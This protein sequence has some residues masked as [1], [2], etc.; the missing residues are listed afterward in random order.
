MKK[1]NFF[2]KKAITFF[3]DLQASTEVYPERYLGEMVAGMILYNPI[4][5]II[6]F[7]GIYFLNRRKRMSGRKA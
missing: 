6:V 3:N 5:T 7:I 2:E 1:L 4:N